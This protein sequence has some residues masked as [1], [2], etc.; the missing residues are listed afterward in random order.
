MSNPKYVFT[1][2]KSN[3]MLYNPVPTIHKFYQICHFENPNT[4]KYHMRAID[5]TQ[6]GKIVK[7]DERKY[8]AVQMFK[9]FKLHKENAY[10]IYPTSELT[11]IDM[12]N[13]VDIFNS[14]SE[15]LNNNCDTYDYAKF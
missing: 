11:L 1:N 14:K 4:K 15:L 6:D 7:A 3:D 12:P 13:A 5:F 9:F 2:K 10:K 8:N